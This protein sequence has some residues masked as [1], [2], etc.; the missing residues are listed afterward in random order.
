MFYITITNVPPKAT[1]DD[2]YKALGEA[3][4]AR[5]FPIQNKE[6]WFDLQFFDRREVFR[7]VEE[8][9]EKLMGNEFELLLSAF[10]RRKT[11]RERSA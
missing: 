9:S 7:A 10:I 2:I 3:D 11:Y 8:R 6:G 1:D 5:S 4:F